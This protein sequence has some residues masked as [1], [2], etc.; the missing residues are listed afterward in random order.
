[1]FKKQSR[2]RAVIVATLAAAGAANAAGPDLSTIT[3]AIDMSTVGSAILAVG[4]IL[5]VPSV[6]KRGVK[7]V[8]GMLGR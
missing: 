8:L 6:V 3:G 7:I 5:V 1:M 4:A 2:R